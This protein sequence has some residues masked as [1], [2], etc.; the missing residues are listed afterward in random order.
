MLKLINALFEGKPN[1]IIAKKEG[2]ENLP[3]GPKPE[4]GQTKEEAAAQKDAFMKQVTITMIVT[5]HISNYLQY[6][7]PFDGTDMDATD[8]RNRIKGFHAQLS[9]TEAV[10]YDMEQRAKIQEYDLRELRERAKQQARQQAIKK[11]LDPK[12]Y[13]NL[14]H[15]P[16]K[17]TASKYD[18]QI[19]R[20][21]YSDR[22]VM[23]AEVTI[24]QI[25]QSVIQ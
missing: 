21:S 2:D 22:K 25:L 20:R 11:G 3:S 18:R 13:E 19:D 16:K 12:E 4:P 23:Y 14:K 24:V 1:F 5:Q 6:R 10:K 9:K 8:I 17:A 15:P 7:V